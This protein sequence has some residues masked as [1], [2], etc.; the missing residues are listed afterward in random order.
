[1][2]ARPAYSRAAQRVQY[3]AWT[4]EEYSVFQGDTLVACTLVSE[5]GCSWVY[6]PHAI[7]DRI[8][9]TP[10]LLIRNPSLVRNMT[11]DQLHWYAVHPC[12]CS[13]CALLVE[14]YP[15][16][17]EGTMDVAD[18]YPGLIPLLQNCN[19]CRQ[20]LAAPSFDEPFSMRLRFPAA[21]DRL[22]PVSTEL[23]E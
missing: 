5:T 14:E 10:T 8:Y 11:D 7:Q 15:S 18:M 22:H 9:A 21:V 16:L 20:L 2:V 12:Q 1:M 6:L 17:F 3:D 23:L 13:E 4:T 19:A